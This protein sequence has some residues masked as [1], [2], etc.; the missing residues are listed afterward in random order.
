MSAATASSRA[1]R[2]SVSGKVRAVLALGTVLG[3][4]TVATLAAFTDTVTATGSFSTGVLDLKLN[5]QDSTTALTGLT[6][7]AAKP[8]DTTYALL[9]VKNAGSLPFGYTYATTSTTGT[10][11]QVLAAALNFGVASLGT[12]ADTSTAPTCNAGAFTAATTVV[13]AATTKLSA[14]PATAAPRPLGVGQVEYLCVRAEVAPDA[15]NAVQAKSVTATMT[16]T[17]TQQ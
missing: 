13:T 14:G 2:L 15:G 12:A 16:V 3:L 6:M 17:A 1:H 4:G 10:D 11:P 8:G 9:T 5:D 7:T